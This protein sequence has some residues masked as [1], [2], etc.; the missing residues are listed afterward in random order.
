MTLVLQ[1]VGVLAL[2]AAGAIAIG[3]WRLERKLRSLSDAL[4]TAL[5]PGE[6][7]LA[8][9]D[10][11][12]P[13]ELERRIAALRALGFEVAGRYRIPEIE[14]ALVGGLVHEAASLAAAVRVHPGAEP[15][16]ELVA[17]YEDGESLTVSDTTHAGAPDPRPGTRAVHVPGA[18]AGALWA[19]MLAERGDRTLRTR[20]P[21]DFPEGF[22]RHFRE[23]MAWRRARGGM[24]LEE[25]ERIAADLDGVFSPEVVARSRESSR[26]RAASRLDERCREAFATAL[27]EAWES[28]RDRHLIVHVQSSPDEIHLAIVEALDGAGVP[29][30]RVGDVFATLEE[31]V[32]GQPGIPLDQLVEVANRML[33]PEHRLLPR[34]TFEEPVQAILYVVGG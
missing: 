15:F 20:S 17:W 11:P 6:I 10:G 3:L 24:T 5:V 12:L 4:A 29:E 21:G 19:R 9:V 32:G 7:T 2:L 8:A 30:G 31:V 13:D 27:G 26:S 25:I 16:C 18:D 22:E 23:E 34:A 1:V 14:G 33:R 28:V